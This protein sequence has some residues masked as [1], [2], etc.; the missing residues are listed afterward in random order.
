MYPHMNIDDCMTCT[1]RE[2]ELNA[3]KDRQDKSFM[4]HTIIVEEGIKCITYFDM[5]DT[6]NSPTSDQISTL[7]SIF[8]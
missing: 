4:L 7:F 1:S 5:Y 2:M 6:A 8:P 3:L